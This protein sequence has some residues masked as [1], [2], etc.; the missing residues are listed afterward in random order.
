MNILYH[1]LSET[2]EEEIEISQFANSK[3]WI[4]QHLKN[5]LS[6]EYV[7]YILRN[8][9]PPNPRKCLDKTS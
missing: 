7:Q 9:P 2:Q 3:G 5:K 6:E 1:L 8:V 4:Q